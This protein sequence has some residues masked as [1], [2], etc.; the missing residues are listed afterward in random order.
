[1]ITDLPS[2]IF[3]CC[4]GDKKNFSQVFTYKMVAEIMLVSSVLKV[5]YWVFEMSNTKQMRR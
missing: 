3:K 4:Y 2:S 1:M 5:A